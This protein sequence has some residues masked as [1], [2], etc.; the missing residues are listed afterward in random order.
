MALRLPALAQGSHSR[1]ETLMPLV[2]LYHD[3]IQG[4]IQ[5]NA[6]ASGFPGSGAAR[7]KLG[8]TEFN[9]HL[10]AIATSVR[11]PPMLLPSPDAAIPDP[12]SLVLTF[13]DGGL[14]AATVIAGELERR[15]WRGHFFITADYIGQPGFVGRDQIR[16]L[17]RRGHSIGSHSCSHPTRMS[18]CS[19]P[20]LLDEWRRSRDI[21]STILGV[22]VTSASVPGGYYSRA[23]AET[24]A[25][26]GYVQLFNSEP[27]TH[28]TSV[29]G[30]KVIGRYAIYHGMTAQKA[31][32]LAAGS[33]LALWRQS[34]SWKL[35]K[36][37]KTIGGPAYLGLRRMLLD[38]KYQSNQ[39]LS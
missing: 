5:G 34:A 8:L 29:G 23:V 31:A 4:D 38:R 16:D 28:I 30:C 9:A 35:K 18:C 27:T 24:A 11:V 22:P 37:L 12:M 26:A 36:F 32:A 19:R 14:S 39:N 20:Q 1:E 33:T 2:L 13:D 10:E 15:D 25:E 7:Y 3:V 6:D 17:A 21:L